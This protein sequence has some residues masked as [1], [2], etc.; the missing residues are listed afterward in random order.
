MVLFQFVLVKTGA[1]VLPHCWFTL[2]DCENIEPVTLFKKGVSS[3]KHH[4]SMLTSL[5]RSCACRG[6][7]RPKTARFRRT[8][9]P[10]DAGDWENRTGS[11][12]KPIQKSD[13]GF[14][15]G[16][17]FYTVS[18]Y[19]LPF[20]LLGDNIVNVTWL[21]ISCATL[22]WRQCFSMQNNRSS[23]TKACPVIDIK[24]TVLLL[25]SHFLVAFG[26]SLWFFPWLRWQVFTKRAGKTSRC[27]GG[28]SD[29][30]TGSGWGHNRSHSFSH[31]RIQF[32]CAL[33]TLMF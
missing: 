21:R 25:I 22:M 3:S 1:S 6:G 28:D 11:A 15:A 20:T 13:T 31:V 30:A 9:D 8:E 18:Q 26:C 10:D 16:V 23:F 7:G 32:G 4:V 12:A 2:F 24:L 33:W 14:R 29:P 27:W 5:W 19:Y 17:S